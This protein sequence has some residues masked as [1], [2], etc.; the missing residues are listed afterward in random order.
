MDVLERINVNKISVT[1]EKQNNCVAVN[2][3]HTHKKHDDILTLCTN[4][5]SNLNIHLNLSLIVYSDKT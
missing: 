1:V 4:H 2:V 3:T 5:L